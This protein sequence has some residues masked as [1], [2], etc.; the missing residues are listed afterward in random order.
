[1][2][3][4]MRHMKHRCY[5]ISTMCSLSLYCW[6]NYSLF[7]PVNNDFFTPYYQNC[8]LMLV[9]L[10]WDTYHM[11][12]KQV[13]YRTDLMIHHF[14]TLIVYVSGIN[15]ATLQIS[16]VL[17]ME[18]ISLMNYTWRNSPLLLKL[19]RTLCIFGIRIPLSLWFWLYYN[20]Y[21]ADPHLKKT[22]SY[23][24]YLF[25]STI[26]NVYFFFILYDVFILWKLYQPK[27]IKII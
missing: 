18:C 27:K 26:Y 16:N 6:F 17:I 8:I 22:Q 12:T 14:I 2:D 19:Y 21:I 9:Y 5:F 15:Y 24:L 1:M 10:S 25:L 7:E 13:L 3:I 4:Q 11:V 23:T 20:P